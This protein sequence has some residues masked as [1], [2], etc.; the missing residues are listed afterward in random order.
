MAPVLAVGVNPGNPTEN[1]SDLYN[2]TSSAGGPLPSCMGACPAASPVSP[3]DETIV[4]ASLAA[5]T[6]EARLLTLGKMVSLAMNTG[7]SAASSDGGDSAG[8]GAPCGGGGATDAV[9]N[10]ASTCANRVATVGDMNSDVPCFV[11][12]EEA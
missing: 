5:N 12:K 4:L 1:K 7:G 3:E 10:A 2:G 8:G 6:V 9:C 11:H